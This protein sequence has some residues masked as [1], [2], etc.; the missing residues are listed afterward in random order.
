[1]DVLAVVLPQNSAHLV[2]QY[3]QGCLWRPVSPVEEGDVAS[4]PPHLVEIYQRGVQ[5][6]RGSS[7]ADFTNVAGEKPAKL[8]TNNYYDSHYRQRDCTSRLKGPNWKSPT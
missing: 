3:V 6:Y 7:L 5:S 8:Y 4:L 1:M 2:V